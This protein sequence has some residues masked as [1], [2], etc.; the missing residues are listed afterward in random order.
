MNNTTKTFNQTSTL[1]F[2]DTGVDNY[3]QLFDGVVATA[4][5]FILDTAT[6]GI[7]QID[8]IL[9]QYP[10]Q[11]TVHI[12]SHGAPGCLYLG[13]SQLSLDTL[14]QYAPQLQQW[15]IDNLL[16]YGCHVAA[17]DAGEEFVSKLR[18]LTGADIAASHTLTGAAIKGGNWEL[19]V[20]TGQV[21]QPRALQT[22]VMETYSGVFNYQLQVAQNIGG[23]SF[24]RGNGIATDSNS[25]V[26]ATGYFQG[27]ID[28]NSDGIDD[29]TSNG[30]TDSYVAKFDSDGD[31]LLAQNIG[32]GSF[33]RGNGIA[34]DSNG[35]VWATG[36]FSSSIDIDRDGIDDLTS[37]GSDDSY[38]AKF[39]SDGNLLLAQNIGGGSFDRGNGIATDSNGNVWATGFFFGSIDFNS[40][41]T[42]DLTSHGSFDSYVAK[43]DSDGNFQF[44]QNIGGSSDDRGYGIATDSNGNVWATGF[45]F[46][47]ID[48]D[49]DGNNDLTSNNGSR[50][51][52]VAKFDS[53]GNF[54][55]AQN[56]GGSSSDYG[57]GIATDSNGNVWATG[58][59]EGT[60]D[61]DSDGNNDLTSNGSFDSY[62]AKFDSN[63]NLQFAQNIGGGS[64]DWGYGI[65]TDSNGNVWATGYFQGSIDFNSD[66]ID[67]LTSNGSRDSYV[68]K[69]DSD[70]NFL[71][72][73]NIGGSISDWGYGIATDSN[74]NVWATGDFEGTIDID[75]DGT[76]D[77]TSNGDRDSYVVKFSENASP[78]DITLDNNTI[79]EN[80]AGN[81]VVGTL[82]TTDPDS[83]D[84]TFTYNLVSGDG[85]T[86]NAAFTIGG[87]NN[88][89]LLIKA[90]PDYE[91]KD[92]YSIRVQTTD[93]AGATYQEQFT[94]NVNNLDE[95]PTESGTPGRD[96]FRGDNTAENYSALDGHDRVYGNGGE[97]NLDGGDGNDIIYGGD[98]N[99]TLNGGLLHDRL[100]GDSGDDLLLGDSGNDIL[101]GGAGNDTLNGGLGNDRY[102]GGAGDDVFIIGPGL[103][104]DLIQRFEDGMDKIQ[105]EGGIGFDDLV[106]LE[107]GSSTLIKVAATGELLARLSGINVG[108][109]GAD[110]FS[111]SAT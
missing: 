17:G 26:W 35:N 24:D 58:G 44:A 101:N 12:I 42:D 107:S 51:S 103:G 81:S 5:P 69:F 108:L 90:S 109:V 31:F 38:V 16:L 55:F 100:N 99:D 94:I 10:G 74:G 98:D 34:T 102:I 2:I 30:S 47:T 1:V 77:L 72:A 36:F 59:F 52:Y 37:N 87:T 41:G 27:S 40:D 13:N 91:A 82:T 21:N 6:D 80:V 76:D 7:E 32:G 33:D 68:A 89:E 43:F 61:I 28:F 106:R 60:I 25:N 78:T 57:N 65:A 49:S 84:T 46:G 93:A 11:K 63:G 3:Q 75:S 67:D 53:D 15:N 96:I 62:V 83:G 14:K 111:Q 97:D 95:T 64:S 39:D 19:E 4:Q 45:F 71:F 104:I 88:D 54:Q 22:E 86:D 73:Q 8:E 50:D 20:N 79:D 105:L 66:G 92:S 23:S 110:D 29:L 48:I 9:Q 70:G 18:G 56:I 85:D